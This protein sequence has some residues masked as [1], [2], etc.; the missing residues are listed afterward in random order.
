MPS[1]LR[2]WLGIVVT[3]ICYY[4]VHEGAHLLVALALGVF[5]GIRFMGLGMQIL[6]E[7]HGMSNIQLAIFNIIGSAATLIAGYILVLSKHS[8]LLNHKKLLKAS[9]YYATLG[10]LIIDPL[11]L[12][13]L[14]GF[15]GGGDMNGIILFGVPE[16]AVRLVYAVI[17]AINVFVCSKLVYP[18]YKQSFAKRMA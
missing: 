10:L 11:Y 6:I 12:S 2:K 16:I 9:C 5:R 13:A 1:N 18:A 3:I 17:L 4:A 8:I 14:C 7:V 15:F